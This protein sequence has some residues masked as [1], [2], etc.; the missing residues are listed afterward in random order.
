MYFKLQGYDAVPCS[1]DEWCIWAQDEPC[2]RVANTLVG[3]MRVSTVF[4]GID[5][6]F[7]RDCEPLLFE[8]MI[9]ENGK[10]ILD[11]QKRYSTW[12][13]ATEGH[14]EAVWYAESLNI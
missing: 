9:F 5:H 14:A 3:D 7:L 2:R 1:F 12:D 10:A 4:L 6:N 8:T 11:Y 13:A